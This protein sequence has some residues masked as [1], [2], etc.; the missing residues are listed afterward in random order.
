MMDER[1]TAR[2]GLR[3]VRIGEADVLGPPRRGAALVPVLTEAVTAPT[4]ERYD[5]QL[6]AF[7]AWLRRHGLRSLE[8]LARADDRAVNAALSA[9]LQ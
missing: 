7:D 9:R 5:A 1:T 2:Y 6:A 3:A 4:L 8:S